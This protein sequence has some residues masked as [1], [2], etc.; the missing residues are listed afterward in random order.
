M[1]FDSYSRRVFLKSILILFSSFTLFSTT[2]YGNQASDLFNI[3]SVVYS[4]VD[5]QGLKTTRKVDGTWSF[6][7]W[8]IWTTA[9]GNFSYDIELTTQEIH[10]DAT[11]SY[12]IENSIPGTYNLYWDDVLLGKNGTI[13]ILDDIYREIKPGK[14]RR[15]FAIPAESLTLGKHHLRIVGVRSPSIFE[16]KH[17]NFKFLTIEELLSEERQHTITYGSYFVYII[18]GL[19][20]LTTFFAKRDSLL[21]LYLG[22][23]CLLFSTFALNKLVY[24]HMDLSYLK[25]A[26]VLSFVFTLNYVICMLAHLAVFEAFKFSRKIAWLTLPVPFVFSF[27]TENFSSFG[28]LKVTYEWLFLVGMLAI[29]LR[30]KHS[31][32]TTVILASLSIVYSMRLFELQQFVTYAA[33][34]LYLIFSMGLALYKQQKEKQESELTNTRLN[35]ELIKNKIQPHFILNSMTSA[36][37]W[38]ESDPEQGVIFLNALAKEFELL[39]RISEKKLIPLAIEIECCRSYLKV[40]GFRKKSQYDLQLDNVNLGN[41]LPPSII[42]NLIENA[43]THNSFGKRPIQFCLKEFKEGDKRIYEFRSPNRLGQRTQQDFSDGTGIQY[44]KARLMESYRN[45]WKF[46]HGPEDGNWVTRIEV[47]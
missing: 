26:V 40:M 25:A 42:R 23:I 24:Y 47:L 34:L 9:A 46:M 32:L 14:N 44:I 21:Y 10:P 29:I 7:F 15:V 36:M 30:K 43:I 3:E 16:F 28:T 2:I 33:I 8:D 13:E 37:E 38:I 20:F 12:F 11:K 41:T 4:H 17:G 19:F 18:V 39:S 6:G 5:D 27:Y 22:L 1:K 35:L 31:I 45:N